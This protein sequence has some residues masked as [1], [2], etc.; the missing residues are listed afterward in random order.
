MKNQKAFA[1]PISIML[2][3][4]MTL[5]GTALVSVTSSELK[6]NND[7]DKSSQ[8]FYAAETGIAMAKQYMKGANALVPWAAPSVRFCNTDFFPSLRPGQVK[9]MNR[10]VGR[11][12]LNN[13]I[14]APGQ[15]NTRLSKFSYEYFITYTPDKNGRTN[16]FQQK[17]GTNLKY[18]TIYSCGC[19]NDKNRCR[20]GTDNIVPIEAIVTIVE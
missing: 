16:S 15:E 2:L 11:E 8:A 9:A 20:T 6:S 13:V 7:R 3:V 17:P 12:N 19:D 1:L 14:S 5:M 18:Y 4:V 10:H